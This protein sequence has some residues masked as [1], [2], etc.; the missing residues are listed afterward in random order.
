MTNQEIA[1][2][3]KAHAA[4][5][6]QNGSWRWQQAW[7]ITSY[8]ARLTDDGRV[9]WEAKGDN[10]KRSYPQIRDMAKGLPHHSLHNKPVSR[11]NAIRQ[12]G[13][14]RVAR[15]EGSGWKFA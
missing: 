11:A 5:K 15:I 6:K 3:I 8:E 10:G 4:T 13:P 9:I 12:I 2:R 14:G 1:E 7:T